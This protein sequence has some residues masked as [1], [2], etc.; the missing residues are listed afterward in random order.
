MIWQMVYKFVQTMAV[1]LVAGVPA[2]WVLFRQPAVEPTA[3][4]QWVGSATSEERDLADVPSADGADADLG[5]PVRTSVDVGAAPARDPVD[6]LSAARASADVLSAARDSIDARSIDAR[7]LSRVRAWSLWGFGLLIV[8]AGAQLAFVL[9]PIVDGL[10]LLD[11]LIVVAEFLWDST[12]GRYILY[13]LLSG[14]AVA[15]IFSFGVWRGWLGRHQNRFPP[16]SDAASDEFASEARGT[17]PGFAR[18]SLPG[19]RRPPAAAFW[20]I[21]VVAGALLLTLSVAFSGHAIRG[22]AQSVAIG[23]QWL[24]LSA[25]SVWAGGVFSF[26]RL[27]WRQLALAPDKYLIGMR[28]G[29]ATLSRVGGGAVLAFIVT[30]VVLSG[31]YVYGVEVA[32]G[33]LYGRMLIAKLAVVVLILGIAAV[34]RYWVVPQVSNWDRTAEPRFGTVN[35]PAPGSAGGQNAAPGIGQDT[36]PDIGLDSALGIGQD[37]A[38]GIGPDPARGH[39][40]APGRPP[41]A[42]VFSRVAAVLRIEAVV[43]VIVLALSA[44]LTQAPPVSTPGQTEG[45]QWSTTAGPWNVDIAMASAGPAEIVFVVDVADQETGRPAELDVSNYSWTCRAI[46]WESRPWRRKPSRRAATKPVPR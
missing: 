17:V 34:N 23:S 39:A 24:H 45:R 1:V 38:P 13:R 40:A 31:L 42:S 3:G 5:A 28:R 8:S 10:P 32:V 9:G 18:R 21:A 26:A 14:A 44:A 25:V 29:M 36:A 41:V 15:F 19:G 2:F 27:P 7:S 46:S 33:S 20:R 35:E 22:L 12:V 37:T 43:M 30:G 11:Q 16:S 4:P 6:V